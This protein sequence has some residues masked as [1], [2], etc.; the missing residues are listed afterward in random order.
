MAS[1]LEFLSQRHWLHG[2]CCTMPL[3]LQKLTF[4]VDYKFFY[5]T[6]TKKGCFFLY[7]F[8]DRDAGVPFI[9]QIF[10]L[11][12][13]GHV[14]NISLFHLI[15]P[16]KHFYSAK[17][18]PW[19][20]EAYNLAEKEEIVCNALQVLPQKCGITGKEHSPRD[21]DQFL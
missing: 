7:F 9:K 18:G 4:L 17:H 19:H 6:F 10:K 11:N 20:Q 1:D 21:E 13:W 2:I 5:G 12:T 14:S 15:Q 8:T 3:N 16:S